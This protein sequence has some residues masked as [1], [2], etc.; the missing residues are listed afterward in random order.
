MPQASRSLTAASPPALARQRS[1]ALQGLKDALGDATRILPVASTIPS[2]P[3]SRPARA[4]LRRETALAAGNADAF[5]ERSVEV[6]PLRAFRPSLVQ[7]LEGRVN[8]WG[9]ASRAAARQSLTPSE[10]GGTRETI[11][12]EELIA[13]PPCQNNSALRLPRLPGLPRLRQIAGE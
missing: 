13:L 11:L 2:A 8:R 6:A 10:G 3:C 9:S 12:C 5:I 4:A 1:R 7:T